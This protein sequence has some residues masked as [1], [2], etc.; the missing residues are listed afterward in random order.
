M[1]ILALQG[2]PRKKGNTNRVLDEMIKGA[3]D[4]G[5]EIKKYFLNSL[6]I[7]PC[8]G[9]ERCAKGKDCQFEDDGA[10]IINQLAD[11]ASVILASPIYFGQMT[12]QAKTIVDRFYSIFN[13]PDKKF[14]GKAAMIFT[15]AFPDKDI[16][17]PYIKLTEAQPFLNNTELEYI[18]TLEV[19]GV[20]EI[21]DADNAEDDLKKAYDIGQKF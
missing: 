9:C 8:N 2:S 4:N 16:Y 20:K 15:H 12:A 5:H 13:N 10:E 14:D 21:G 7:S 19:A 3:E 17:Q 11:G 1:K 6:D 18:E